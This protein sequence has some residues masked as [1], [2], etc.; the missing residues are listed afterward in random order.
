MEFVR[1]LTCILQSVWGANQV[2][3]PVRVSKFDVTDAYHSGT[4]RPSQVGAFAYIIPLSL[5][6]DDIIILINLVLPMGWVDSPNILLAFSETLTDFANA[7][8]DTELPVLSL[9]AIAKNPM[10]QRMRVK[11]WVNPPIPSAVRG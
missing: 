10:S 5:G 7:L 3:G 8:V 4:L 2:Q 11:Y 6:D 1:A 9:G